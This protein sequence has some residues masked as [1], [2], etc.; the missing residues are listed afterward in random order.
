MAYWMAART[1]RLRALFADGLDADAAALRE[2]NLGDAHL[3][4]QEI[5]DLLGARRVGFPLDAGVDVFGV[6]AEDDHVDQFR[7]LD[8]ARARR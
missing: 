7:V 8:R 3:V 5:D 2:A 4:L 6:L 1:R